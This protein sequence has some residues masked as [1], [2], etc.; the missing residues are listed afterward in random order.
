MQLK[1]AIDECAID[2][3]SDYFQDCIKEEQA[4]RLSVADREKQEYERLK[5]KYG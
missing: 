4:Y 5:K 2:K 1:I 3:V